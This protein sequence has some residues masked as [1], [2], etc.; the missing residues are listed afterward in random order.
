MRGGLTIRKFQPEHLACFDCREGSTPEEREAD[1]AVWSKYKGVGWTAILGEHVIACGGMIIVRPGV[2]VPWIAASAE[3]AK[4]GIWITRMAKRLLPRA[5]RQLGIERVEVA[6]ME[7][8]ERNQLWAK[9]L[10]FQLREPVE[11]QL[12]FK[13]RRYIQHDLVRSEG[14]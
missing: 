3:I 6:I 12:D 2:G 13:G 10:G 4:H 9:R 8:S 1:I 11:T 5:M 7:T 14:N